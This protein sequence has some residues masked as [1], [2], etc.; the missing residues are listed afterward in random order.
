MIARRHLSRLRGCL[1]WF[2]P[3]T[4][5][6]T[7]GAA[8]SV[9]VNIPTKRK[10]QIHTKFSGWSHSLTNHQL[11]TGKHSTG[12]IMLLYPPAGKT[13]QQKPLQAVLYPSYDT[14]PLSGRETGSPPLVLSYLA[15]TNS[16]SALP[17]VR[18]NNTPKCGF[19]RHPHL[20]RDRAR[21]RT[22]G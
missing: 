10:T 19:P 1:L 16:P 4:T 14:F 5:T 6:D 13:F 12:G 20:W 21:V 15:A 22:A 17:R 7:T 9:S 2:F 11:S 3:G 8:I 18:C